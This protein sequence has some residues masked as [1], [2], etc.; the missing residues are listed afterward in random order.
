MTFNEL[1]NY[2]DRL[3]RESSRLAMTHILSDIFKQLSAHEA[4][5]VAYFCIG[6][7]NPPYKKTVVGL[8]DKSVI[9]V[10]AHVMHCS[11]DHVKKLLV[12]AADLGEV[13]AQGH[14][15]PTKEISITTVYHDLV[16]I[17]HITGDGAQEA[18]ATAL[19]E[20]LLKVNPLAAK[21]VVRIVLGILR[22]GFSDMTLIDAFSWMVAG[23]KSMSDVIETAYNQCADIGYVATVL[24]EQGIAGVKNLSITV[25]IPIRPAA[26][27]RLSSPQEIIA[28]LGP[29]VAEPKLDGFRL[30]VH[31]DNRHG[32]KKI[33]FFSRNLL[34]MSDMYPDLVKALAPLDVQTF[35]GEG[36]AIAYDAD[37]G[38]FMP[39][40][41]TV[42]RKRKHDIA[43]KV[44]ELP[45]QLFFFDILYLDGESLMALSMMER[46]KKLVAVLKRSSIDKHVVRVTQEVTIADAA[47]LKDYFLLQVAAGLEGVVVKRPGAE[48]QPGKRNF[49]WIKLKRL[50][51]GHLLDSIDCVVL[52][53]Y[54]GSGKRALFGIGALL[55]GVYNKSCDCFQT[56]A[57]V[58]TGFSDDEWRQIK[59]RCDALAVDKAPK[60][61][62]CHKDLVPDVWVRPELVLEITAD[63]ITR[64]PVHTAGVVAHEEGFA[65]R[66]PRFERY[67]DDKDAYEATHV[68]ELRALYAKQK[69]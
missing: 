28:K 63:E 6:E 42:K 55:L 7:L 39:F 13:V 61:V 69:H 43:A 4:Q 21:F 33:C 45:L 66:F 29:C 5:I 31:I 14:W 10:L 65:L 20:L 41:E 8:A 47:T 52:G 9:K 53:Y 67:R 19:G 58:G 54:H 48:Y 51:S 46:R 64:S 56:I 37:T 24:K 25:G 44:Q 2:F 27:E 49:N 16:A 38:S 23:N 22:L 50:E 26:A 60:N 17:T 11:A 12:P 18:K 59:K 30:Q 32:H 3:E 40:Q 34:D 62:S 35:I 68:D 15:Q 1:A 57:K 36:E